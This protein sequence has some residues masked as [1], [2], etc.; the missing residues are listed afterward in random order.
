[1]T[2]PNWNVDSF[3]PLFN[4]SG[5]ATFANPIA[6]SGAVA[7]NAALTMVGDL[8]ITGNL[9]VSG[10][11]S[12]GDAAAD[13]ITMTGD[14]VW[15]ACA[16][17]YLI[18]MDAATPGT[19]DI[20]LSNSATIHNSAAAVL[21]ITEPTINFVAQ[22]ALVH[23]YDATATLTS[24][25][26]SAG[27]CKLATLGSS[28]SFEI[29][30]GD[31]GITLDAANNITLDA[32]S[33]DVDFSNDAL[34]ATDKKVE[35]RSVSNYINSPSAGN[36]EIAS[37]A[38][39][40]DGDITIDGAHTFA[41]GS[42]AVSLNGAVAL[43]TTVG[44]TSG[45]GSSIGGTHIIY[46]DGAGAM[47]LHIIPGTSIALNETN[48]S[49][50]G[51][52]KLDGTLTLDDDGTI[53]DASDIMTLTQ[54]TITLVGATAINIDGPT[55][56]TGLF[57]MDSIVAGN[58]FS[59]AAF[60]DGAGLAMTDSSLDAAAFYMELPSGGAVIT[61]GNV[62]RGI[63]T[64]F[65]INQAQTENISIYA[66][67]GHIRVKANLAAGVHVGQM[68]YYEQSGTVSIATG[69]I[70]S[71]MAATVEGDASLTI[72]SGAVMSAGYFSSNLHASTTMNGDFV[73]VKI[74][75][76]SGCLDF[77]SG[78]EFTDCMSGQV[79]KFAD[80]GTIV[81]VTNGSILNDI[82][83]TANAGFIKV[84][85]GSDTR[86]IAVYSAKS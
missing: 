66:N 72:D 27:V 39:L 48:I 12:F 14:I 57:T 79:L 77:V 68:C 80:D 41:T 70:E 45:T 55:T 26:S 30:T 83:G 61:A 40:M 67:T 25:V 76:G 56:V 19:A 29:E 9:S 69:G 8:D 63:R 54:D 53:A 6:F 84:L 7:I 17:T 60:G 15:A 37:A 36:M 38:I 82:H 1:M 78:I 21:D 49:L 5:I 64:R 85:I 65:L 74:L 34:F 44:Y 11:F 51:A 22:T 71:A 2:D 75:K 43:A 4:R 13:T 31:G 10:N 3:Y 46:Q 35:F 81:S 24:T 20:R 18:D 42:G 73:G 52:I 33:G 23:K 62:L 50:T 16:P 47:S 86:Y 58:V 28:D 32:G 59:L